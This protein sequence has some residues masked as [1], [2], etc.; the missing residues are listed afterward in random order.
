M[1]RIAFL[2]GVATAVFAIVAP[3]A[4]AGNASKSRTNQVRIHVQPTISHEQSG[5]TLW[6][7]GNRL[8]Y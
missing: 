7:A 6:R 4:T 2:A 5:Q 8:L 3:T 1:K